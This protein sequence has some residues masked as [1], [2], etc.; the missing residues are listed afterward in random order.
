MGLWEE[1]LYPGLFISS[2]K[3]GEAAKTRRLNVS[4]AAAEGNGGSFFPA[5]SAAGRLGD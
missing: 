3:A 5:I 4:S 1:D 2:T